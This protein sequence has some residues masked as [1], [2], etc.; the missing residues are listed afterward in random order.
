MRDERLVI[1]L[2]LFHL[3]AA[4]PG[5]ALLHALGLVRLR[6]WPLAAAAGPAVLLGLIVTGIPLIVLAVLGVPV[7]TITALIVVVVATLVFA[8]LGRRTRDRLAPLPAAGVP[9]F[10]ER[11][12]EWLVLGGAAL[13][14][15]IGAR[16]FMNLDT[17]WDDANIWSLRAL[18][19]FHFEGFVDGISRNPE[20][21]GVHLDYPILQPLIEANFFHAIGAVDLRLWH[22]ELWL[23]LTLVIWTLAWLL[24]PLGRRWLWTVVLGTLALSAIPVSNITL[25]DADL[26]MAGMVGCATLCFGIWLERGSRAHIILGAIFLA[27]AANVKNEGLVFGVALAVALCAAAAFV[28]R[29]GRLRDLALSAAIVVIAAL[30][31]QLWVIGNDA[32][33]RATES[34]WQAIQD[35]GRLVDRLD[36][37][38]RGLGQVISQLMNTAEWNLL[39]PAFLVAAV[40]FLW[41]GLRRPVAAFYLGAGVLAYLSVAYVYWVTPFSDL[42]GFE[43]RTGDRIVLGVV[44]IAGAGLAHLLELAATP[45]PEPHTPDP[46]ATEPAEVAV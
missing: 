20:L 27:G 37:L 26:L 16:A 7:N 11:P 35:P 5:M 25:G 19:L 8:A 17:L 13:Y 2:V 32:A 41:T 29:P 45:R 44:L 4:A 34:P 12:I 24:A 21:S 18:G 40:A 15:L 33:T 14:F 1:G 46:A 9:R 42:G 10:A 28:R 23:L 6:P 30:P 36:Y 3:L 39:I 22:A 38:W 43:Q 31:W